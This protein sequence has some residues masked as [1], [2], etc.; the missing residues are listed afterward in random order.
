MQ[1]RESLNEARP[2]RFA[3]VRQT[4]FIS[5]CEITVTV[6]TVQRHVRQLKRTV[7]GLQLESWLLAVL[8]VFISNDFLVQIPNMQPSA[9]EFHSQHRGQSQGLSSHQP[10]TKHD[11]ESCQLCAA[12]P[13]A[14]AGLNLA[15]LGKTRRG[16]L[17]PVPALSVQHGKP[18]H[19]IGL[20]SR[21]PP[22]V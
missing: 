16:V 17:E 14:L 3:A 20:R 1:S 18:E 8:V 2:T 12:P 10:H 7:R 19:R 21:A 13:L 5:L 9:S 22:V 15:H 6:I 11:H 4:F